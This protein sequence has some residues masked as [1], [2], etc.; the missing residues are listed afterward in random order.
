MKTEQGFIMPERDEVVEETYT[1]LGVQ[2]DILQAW[3]HLMANPRLPDEIDVKAWE[4]AVSYLIID[5]EKHYKNM[6]E[7]SAKKYSFNMFGAGIDWKFAREL[8]KERR[9][10]PGFVI[11]WE[12]EGKLVPLM[13]DGHHRLGSKL[14]HGEE[15]MEVYVFTPEEFKELYPRNYEILAHG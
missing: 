1:M 15:K 13:I 5:G 3:E 12:D 8:S 14:I 7:V 9:D 2:F 6:S 11:T 10:I 4:D